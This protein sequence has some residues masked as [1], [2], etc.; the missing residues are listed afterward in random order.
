MARRCPLLF[1]LD[2]AWRRVNVYGTID[3]YMALTLDRRLD[4]IKSETKQKRT[5]QQTEREDK[6]RYTEQET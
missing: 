4:T 3:V 5:S 2:L 6:L 1:L